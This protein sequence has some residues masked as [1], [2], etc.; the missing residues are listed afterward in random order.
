MSAI[1]EV[2]EACET[3]RRVLNGD[4]CM[5]EV[6]EAY[7][8][9]IELLVSCRISPEL[10]DRFKNF[11]HNEFMIVQYGLL[12]Q[13]GASYVF[14]TEEEDTIV[15][16]LDGVKYDYPAGPISG[17]LLEHILEHKHDKEKLKSAVLEFFK[18]D[19]D[20]Y[21]RKFGFMI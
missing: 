12:M 5:N 8:D 11:Y 17:Y 7:R 9:I 1:K 3:V 19:L 16:S 6:Y 21:L 4:G 20:S 10:F 18:N 13:A 15:F 2:L 14:Y